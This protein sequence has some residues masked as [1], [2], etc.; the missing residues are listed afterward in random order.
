MDLP[1]FSGTEAQQG[2]STERIKYY[3]RDSARTFLQD[4]F[5]ENP[6]EGVDPLQQVTGMSVDQLIQFAKGAGLEVSLAT[7]GMLEDVLLK[8]GGKGGRGGGDRSS[9]QLPLISRAGSTVVEN[10][11]SRSIY[12]LPTVTE[13][14]SSNPSADVTD[15]QPCSSRQTDEIISFSE[16][17]VTDNAESVSLKTLGQIHYDIRRMKSGNLYKWSKEGRPNPLRPT[18]SNEEGYVFT[19]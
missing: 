8:I 7:F 10:I 16:T 14:A 15:Q 6:P 2:V 3:P 12:C 5:M 18:G 13:S 11:A 19:D 9:G 4:C 17:E 1:S